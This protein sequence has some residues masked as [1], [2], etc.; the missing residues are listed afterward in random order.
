MENWSYCS[1]HLLYSV[2]NVLSKLS[3]FRISSALQT[4]YLGNRLRLLSLP[5]LMN[6][7]YDRSHRYVS[8]RFDN[9][10]FLVCF[11]I[12]EDPFVGPLLYL[13]WTSGDVC[14]G[15]QA[16]VDPHACML[17]RLHAT[18][19]SDSPLVWHLLTSWQPAWRQ[20][21][22]NQLENFDPLFHMGENVVISL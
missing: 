7:A 22:S 11:L 19:S 12:L 9:L 17:H 21:R 1:K 10:S 8:I 15:F 4:S 20:S 16:R 5:V 18:E 13:F 2:T 6:D 3:P 14:L